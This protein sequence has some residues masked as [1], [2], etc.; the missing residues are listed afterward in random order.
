MQ[1]ALYPISPMQ[2]ISTRV[3]RNWV[4]LGLLSLML[5]LLGPA[6]AQQSLTAR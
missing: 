5:F 3:C 6:L 2:G 1:I 4:K